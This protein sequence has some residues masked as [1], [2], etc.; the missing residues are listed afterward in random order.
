M[1]IYPWTIAEQ[2]GPV[3]PPYQGTGTADQANLVI[4]GFA[5]MNVMLLHSTLVC[6][7]PVIEHKIESMEVTLGNGKIYWTSHMMMMMCQGWKMWDQK[8]QD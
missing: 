2:S 3:W 7:L 1:L 5:Q 8:V 4:L 6:Q